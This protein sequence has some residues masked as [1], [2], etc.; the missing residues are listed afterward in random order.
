MS[1]IDDSH[2]NNNE[3]ESKDNEEVFALFTS[4][5]QVWKVIHTTVPV[6][7]PETFPDGVAIVYNIT[8]WKNHMD[9]FSDVSKY[10][11]Y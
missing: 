8:G 7:Y 2:H 5:L 3:S 4:K 10:C 6:E 9:A 1:I 11:L